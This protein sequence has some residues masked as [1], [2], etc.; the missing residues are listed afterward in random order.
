MY[1]HVYSLSGLEV[2]RLL[3]VPHT[4]HHRLAHLRL[5]TLTWTPSSPWLSSLYL[6][7]S[8]FFPQVLLTL[9]SR[10]CVV[11]VTCLLFNLF[12]KTLTP[13]TCFLTLSALVTRGLFYD[14]CCFHYIF[15]LLVM[16]FWNIMLTFTAMRT[17]HSYT[18][19]WNMVKP[20][21]CPPWKP[22]FQT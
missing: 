18:F 1:C 6:S 3:I 5:M 22:V 13:W 7:L 10:L 4:C 17:I 11:C 20:Q 9:F 16:S 2:I 12:I 19:R 15:Y 8:W 21:N 14:L